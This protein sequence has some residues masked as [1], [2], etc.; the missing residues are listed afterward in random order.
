MLPAQCQ[1]LYWMSEMPGRRHWFL[2][3]QTHP[4]VQSFALRCFP[5]PPNPIHHLIHQLKSH[6]PRRV[7]RDNPA[8]KEL[9]SSK[10][11]WLTAH[12]T[13]TCSVLPHGR[14]LP[15]EVPAI[16]LDCGLPWGTRVC[17]LSLSTS[18]PVGHLLEL[19]KVHQIG[20]N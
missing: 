16:P 17:L 9:A 15:L 14:T 13:G 6:L 11:C 3:A 18:P 4:Q 8:P 20:Q 19:A 1:V 10:L 2:H 12:R 7:L 5:P